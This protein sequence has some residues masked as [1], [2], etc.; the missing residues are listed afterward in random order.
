[1]DVRDMPSSRSQIDRVAKT[2]D[3]GKPLAMPNRNM[4]RKRGSRS[5]AVQDL[6]GRATFVEFAMGDS[7]R[8]TRALAR[9]ARMAEFASIRDN[10]ILQ[11]SIPV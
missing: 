1:M 4:D 9:T 5:R 8:Q 7:R 6:F 10:Y 2:S 3:D 11:A